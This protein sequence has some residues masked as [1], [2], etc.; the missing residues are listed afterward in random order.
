MC[1]CTNSMWPCG[2]NTAGGTSVW[3]GRLHLS[4]LPLNPTPSL[5]A[6]LTHW[7]PHSLPPIL[8]PLPQTI[9]HPPQ[10]PQHRPGQPARRC[11]CQYNSVHFPA[12]SWPLIVK[13][14]WSGARVPHSY[15]PD[16]L[17]AG[18][19]THT[20]ASYICRSA[21]VVRE[22]LFCERILS[23]GGYCGL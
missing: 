2:S 17:S 16:V 22:K 23:A 13:P 14:R 7:L 9:P 8:L 10:V 21:C 12:R 5:R 6:S 3:V 20:P 18:V 11:C 1:V 4:S 15:L 19:A